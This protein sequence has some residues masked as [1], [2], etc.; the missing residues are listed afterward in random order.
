VLPHGRAANAL[1]PFTEFFDNKFFSA[2]MH[3]TTN[4]K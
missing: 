1:N 3:G 2:V 4:F